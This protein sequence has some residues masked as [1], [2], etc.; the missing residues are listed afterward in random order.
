M[1]RFENVCALVSMRVCMIVLA[2][3]EQQQEQ[4]LRNSAATNEDAATPW[5]VWKTHF[6]NTF[7]GEK[8]MWWHVFTRVVAVV[9]DLPLKNQAE[10]FFPANSQFDAFR[11]GHFSQYNILQ[12]LLTLNS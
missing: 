11:K 2:G 12:S 1:S 9:M 8:Y 6:Y 7:N 4:R 10:T 5:W 3:K